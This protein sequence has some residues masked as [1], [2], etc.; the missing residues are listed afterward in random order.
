MIRSSLSIFGIRALEVFYRFLCVNIYAG[1]PIEEGCAGPSWIY[2]FFPES[3]IQVEI[4]SRLD[5]EWI[6]PDDYFLWKSWPSENDIAVAV[7]GTGCT[8]A[9]EYDVATSTILICTGWA[10]TITNEGSMIYHGPRSDPRS[11]IC[12][13]VPFG[14]TLAGTDIGETLSVEKILTF[15]DNNWTRD[16]GFARQV[17]ALLYSRNNY[18]GMINQEVTWDT[19]ILLPVVKTTY[20]AETVHRFDI[21]EF[22]H[23]WYQGTVLS[24]KV[25]MN[26]PILS[27]DGSR[28]SAVQ[29]RQG[30]N[31]IDALKLKYAAESDEFDKYR[32]PD[33][34]P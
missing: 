14:Y 33:L 28:N 8:K 29:I 16:T 12:I 20:T 34:T 21:K 31:I 15:E 4:S 32:N 10:L 2:G 5:V 19:D 22:S 7:D 18:N 6:F 13:L 11:E 1:T 23:Y 24:E 26:M 3:P 9:F 17:Y 27:F 25:W 30:V